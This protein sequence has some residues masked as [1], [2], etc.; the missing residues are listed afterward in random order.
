MDR[1]RLGQIEFW[2]TQNIPAPLRN[3]INEII[4]TGGP[5]IVDDIVNEVVLVIESEDENTDIYTL[6]LV[7]ILVDVFGPNHIFFF[8]AG[9]YRSNLLAFE[10]ANYAYVG[11]GDIIDYLLEQG[12]D[13][14]ISGENPED[15]PI[16]NICK[17][18]DN[19]I[20]ILRKL[21]NAG[22][23]C[24]IS[25]IGA[26]GYFSPLY[27]SLRYGHFDYIYEM[28]IYGLNINGYDEE[29]I[30]NTPLH[31]CFSFYFNRYSGSI[32]R[33]QDFSIF[34][35]ISS[36]EKLFLNGLKIRGGISYTAILLKQFY[37]NNLAH[38]PNY[39]SLI[40]KL[41][42]LLLDYCDNPNSSY[43]DPHSSEAIYPLDSVP[44]AWDLGRLPRK[45]YIRFNS[46]NLY[47]LLL[48]Y[49]AHKM[50]YDEPKVND[51]RDQLNL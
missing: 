29:N 50:S 11:R 8:P 32:V 1:E 31:A 23:D 2:N 37:N 13:P 6:D 14:N 3:R 28:Q 18:Y 15:L 36:I 40:F 47:K 46:E 22:A 48:L 9:G 4:A 49:G 16:I 38:L 26:P 35:I 12:S 27:T 34:E 20:D 24:N 19:N 33:N 45:N 44:I 42:K 51:I 25:G 30:D 39:N 5:Y 17:D 41:V 21:L 7:K 43:E 10:C